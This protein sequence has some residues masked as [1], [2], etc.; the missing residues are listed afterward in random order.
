[1]AVEVTREILPPWPTSGSAACTPRRRVGEIGAVSQWQTPRW[2]PPAG[3]NVDV[4]D[5]SPLAG[6]SPCVPLA[7]K[8]AKGS[9]FHRCRAV[10]GYT[11]PLRMLTL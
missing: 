3:D 11:P 10:R 8:R 6:D 5:V 2:N 4:T 7:V 9:R 1:M